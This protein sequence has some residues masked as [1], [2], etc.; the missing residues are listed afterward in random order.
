MYLNT[1]RM[2]K[3]NTNYTVL[4]FHIFH[5]LVDTVY[6]L[7]PAI[8]YFCCYKCDVFILTL[9]VPHVIFIQNI[10]FQS[11]IPISLAGM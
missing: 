3:I 7:L 9:L 1:E 2:V 4:D 8:L 5:V 6:K 10:L 11:Y